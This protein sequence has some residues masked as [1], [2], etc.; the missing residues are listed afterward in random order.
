MGLLDLYKIV[1]RDKQTNRVIQIHEEYEAWVPRIKARYPDYKVTVT[2][3]TN[4]YPN[5]E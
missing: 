3:L 2:K 4:H 1:V 5:G